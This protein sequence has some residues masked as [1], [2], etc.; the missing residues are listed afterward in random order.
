MSCPAREGRK[1]SRRVEE[2]EPAGRQRP[3][4]R[5]DMDTA[6]TR[7]LVTPPRATVAQDRTPY[8]DAL[9]A[10]SN[11]GP[12]RLHVPGH[13]GGQGADDLLL[14]AY[15]KGALGLDIPAGMHGIDLGRA[16][17]PL[18]RALSLA[19][20]AWGARRTWFL[21]NGASEGSLAACLALA[22]GGD[23]VVVQR[24]VHISTIHGIVLSGL[25]PRFV[26]PE[27]DVAL[28][29]AHTPTPESLDR[30]LAASPGAVAAI[31]VSP[32][33]FGATAD[34]RRL[35][36]VAHARGAVLVV[37][38]AWGAHFAFHD[39]LPEDALSAGADLVVSGTHKVVGSLTQSAMLH[40]GRSAR[41]PLDEASISHALSLIQSTSPNALLLASL[42]AARRQAAIAGRLALDETLEQ[43][44]AAREALRA[45]PGLEVLDAGIAGT[46]G[47]YD[48]D[49]L[50]LT[51]DVRGLGC[52]GYELAERLREVSDLNLELVTET[53]VV[54]HFGMADGRTS[55]GDAVVAAFAAALD[56]LPDGSTWPPRRRRFARPPHYGAQ[57]ISPRTAFFAPHRAVD[58]ADAVGAVAAES[59]SVYP[60]GIA[61]TVPGERLTEE[62]VRYLE[63][64]RRQGGTLRAVGGQAATR[65]KVVDCG[66]L[67][68]SK[69]V[70]A[71]EPAASSF[72]RFPARAYLDKYY[73]RMGPENASL[74]RAIMY[75]VSRLRAATGSVIEV[76]G[77]PSLLSMMALA[78][79]R[80][81]PFERVTFT[82]LSDENLSEVRGWLDGRPGRFDYGHV[83]RW[84]EEEC[85]TASERIVD[86]LRPSTWEL[87]RT[88]WR[89][90]APTR[91]LRGYDVVA[92]HFFADSVTRRTDEF[93][94]LLSKVG[95]L[96]KPGGCVLLSML[97]GSTGYPVAGQRFPAVS[98][99]P[100]DIPS[101]LNRAGVELLDVDVS[102]VEADEPG[103]EPGY[104][105]L[106][107][108]SGRVP[109]ADRSRPTGRE[110]S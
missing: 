110:E 89:L 2:V 28:Q 74:A 78:A 35:T 7:Y 65:I 20:E 101:V 105:G 104:R 36:E 76:G 63:R 50:R 17:T 71:G 21:V 6:D 24:N 75:G 54:P 3:F 68:D 5:R 91:W 100:D 19:A 86:T 16:P 49:L 88:D 25:Q 34:V 12:W 53:V 44:A 83:L 42:D 64:T 9:R 58:F 102:A 11:R 27:F 55:L 97:W 22:R 61:V 38:E 81:R 43:V 40:L 14:D 31:V 46:P 51:V 79:C 107:F 23:R 93:L 85:G 32:T 37:D 8:L 59:L 103:E 13:K 96:G 10:Y 4:G 48:F 109:P 47:V 70:G 26:A 52:S 66:L 108:V 30:A 90:P 98:L 67:D 92:S 33:Y 99:E 41:P 95:R 82:D 80:D 45:M 1:A 69:L 57:A 18:Q 106:I 72:D 56:G 94:E 60:P 15:G 84:L 87:E 73:G 29:I 62:T 77:G 39:E